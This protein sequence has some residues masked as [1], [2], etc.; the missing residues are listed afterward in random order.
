MTFM[1]MKKCPVLTRGRGQH[2]AFGI[3]VT[4][5]PGVIFR[6]PTAA[7]LGLL[8]AWVFA[9]AWE[10]S[11]PWLAKKFFVTWAHPFG[12][13]IDLIAYIVGGTVAFITVCEIL[14]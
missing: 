13:A 8:F 9:M 3:F 5:L 11:T 10:F 6:S 12:D 7:G 2:A 4:A 14:K 1:R